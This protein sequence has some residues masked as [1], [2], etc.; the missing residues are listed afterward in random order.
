MEIGSFSYYQKHNS[1]KVS[2]VR[3]NLTYIVQGEG[4]PQY[5]GVESQCFC[6]LGANADFRTLGP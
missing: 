2:F 1:V 3:Q 5:W 4:G 6:D